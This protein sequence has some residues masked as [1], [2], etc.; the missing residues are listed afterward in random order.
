MVDD[1][2][3]SNSDEDEVRDIPSVPLRGLDDDEVAENP[4]EVHP[5]DD[6]LGLNRDE[7]DP[8][9]SIDACR[10]TIFGCHHFRRNC[11]SLSLSTSQTQCYPALEQ[12][13][14]VSQRANL[15]QYSLGVSPKQSCQVA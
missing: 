12:P 6:Q 9:N 3:V 5:D 11:S 10:H 13:L 2:L 1:E 15:Q 14:G 7:A 4:D 8:D